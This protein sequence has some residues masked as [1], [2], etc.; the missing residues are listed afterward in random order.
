LGGTAERALAWYGY[1]KSQR[2][3]KRISAL[4]PSARKTSHQL[5]EA[6]FAGGYRIQAPHCENAIS[7]EYSRWRGPLRC[8]LHLESLSSFSEDESAE[9]NNGWADSQPKRGLRLG[10]H[11]EAEQN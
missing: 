6:S 11:G 10:Y 3:D 2:I 5:D 7:R 1:S 8:H 4:P 9:W